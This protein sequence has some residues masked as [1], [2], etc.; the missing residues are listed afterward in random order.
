SPRVVRR[1]QMVARLA[2]SRQL[3]TACAFHG[4]E[5]RAH[6][7]RGAAGVGCGG[8]GVANVH[9]RARHRRADRQRS[10]SG[11]RRPLRDRSGGMDAYWAGPRRAKW[12]PYRR[13]VRQAIRQAYRA[14]VDHRV[15]GGRSGTK[16]GNNRLGRGVER[17]RGSPGKGSAPEQERLPARVRNA[18]S[19]TLRRVQR[20]WGRSAAVQSRFVS[21][22]RRAAAQE[23]SPLRLWECPRKIP[24][25]A[26]RRRGR[27]G[28]C[29]GMPKPL[30]RLPGVESPFVLRAELLTLVPHSMSTIDRLEAEGQLPGRIRL[31]PTSRVAWLRRE[32]T[33]YLRHFAKRRQSAEAIPSVPGVA[34]NITRQR[35]G[36][37]H[38]DR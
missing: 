36:S 14:L 3:G 16:A 29:G 4:Q 26:T 35:V 13:V 22:R 27:N 31:E 24:Q 17:G 12:R 2:S 15:A 8:R 25:S 5:T 32:V 34:R 33:A 11:K 19:G 28:H 1:L 37:N 7:V 21:W 23:V 38:Y 18:D 30:R 9:R 6:V 20:G 10:A